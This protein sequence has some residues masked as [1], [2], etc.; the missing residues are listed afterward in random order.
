M[1]NI[2]LHASCPFPSFSYKVLLFYMAGKRDVGVDMVKSL[3]NTKY[4]VDEKLEK[5]FITLFGK[6]PDASSEAATGLIDSHESIDRDVPLEP[7]KHYES[8]VEDEDSASDEEVDEEGETEDEND[9]ESL[10]GETKHNVK[11][12]I[13]LQGGRVRRKAVFDNE[14]DINYKVMLWQYTF[15]SVFFHNI[16]N[17]ICGKPNNLYE[18]SFRKI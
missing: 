1:C 17:I 8:D 6:K 11:E 18:G 5:S 3:Q 9:Q 13:A 2:T 10:D 7:V 12:N 4:S 14:M 16:F 15:R